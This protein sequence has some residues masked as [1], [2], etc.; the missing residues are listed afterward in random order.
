MNR[1]SLRFLPLLVAL[2][3]IGSA[4][5]QV[6]RPLRLAITGDEGTLTPY[7][8]VTGYPGYELMT[9]IYDQLFLM[10]EEL[11]PRPWLAVGLEIVDDVVYVLELREGV[12]WHDGEPFTAD[13]VA[14]TIAYYQTHPMGRFTSSANRV[15]DVQVEGVS[16]VTLMLDGPDATFVEA[17]LADLP[18]LPR[19][20]W[21]GVEEPR[22]IARSG[23]A[24]RTA[25]EPAGTGRTA[26]S[27]SPASSAWKV[28][29]SSRTIG[30]M[31][32]STAGG[33]PQK[34]GLA[35]RR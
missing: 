2:L 31:I 13:D 32:V 27:I 6:D 24:C 1:S 16:S 35:S 10:D 34:S 29:V 19:H 22:A 4:E 18:I 20:L 21:Q 11:V 14:F 7:T 12:R 26:A 9:L 8:Y 25:T 30:A 5:A 15:I 33:G 17:V 23:R 28:V 3:W